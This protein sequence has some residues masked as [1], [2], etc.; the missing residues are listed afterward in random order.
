MTRFYFT[1]QTFL[2]PFGVWHFTKQ[3]ILKDGLEL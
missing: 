1:P 3:L 2:E